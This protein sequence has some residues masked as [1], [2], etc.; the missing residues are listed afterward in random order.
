MMASRDQDASRL[1]EVNVSTWGG[2][3]TIVRKR[4][5]FAKHSQQN[6]GCACINKIASPR[7]GLTMAGPLAR[8]LTG[9]VYNY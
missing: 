8:L 5:M 3:P 4:F 2:D 6:R 7:E 1:T 9:W